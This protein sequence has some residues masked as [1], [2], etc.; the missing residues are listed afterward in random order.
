MDPVNM[1]AGVLLF[2][3]E[4]TVNAANIYVLDI[5]DG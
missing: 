1:S 4:A 3:I 2:W 5:L